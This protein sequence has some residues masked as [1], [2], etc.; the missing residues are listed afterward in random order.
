MNTANRPQAFG[1]K[2]LHYPNAIEFT[3][4]MILILGVIV[5]LGIIDS[6]F[7]QV[8]FTD[9]YAQILFLAAAACSSAIICISL[10]TYLMRDSLFF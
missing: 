6:G 9:T 1:G 2:E 7:G 8:L 4:V 3:V 10:K 5:I